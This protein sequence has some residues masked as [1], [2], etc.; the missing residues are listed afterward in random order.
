MRDS[1]HVDQRPAVA[2]E[3]ADQLPPASDAVAGYLTDIVRELAV[4]N[5][6]LAA[7][8]LFGSAATG[9]YEAGVSD[10]DVLLVVHDDTTAEARRALAAAIEALERRHGLAKERAGTVS[11]L[12]AF[13]DRIT[14]NGRAF[15]ICTRT[16]LLSGEPARI[17]GISRAQ[18]AFVDRIAIPSIVASGVTVWGED[19]LAHVPLPVIRRLDVA[20]SCFSLCN[21]VLF[22]A[23]AYPLLPRA[24]RYA[25]DALKRAVHACYF[26]HELRPAP[27]PAEI[28]FLQRYGPAPTLDRLL[29][30]RAAYG[31]SFGFVLRCLPAIARLHLR[32]ALALRFPRAPEQRTRP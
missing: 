30:L 32:T 13:A 15:F 17:L 3:A 27:L 29:E 10:T 25:M 2:R 7:V 24:T 12:E 4:E 11:A 21:Q 26:C 6:V 1:R 28:A 19:L 22:S 16:D 14:A 5:G 8:V 31:A 20:K 9:G 23:A 18:A